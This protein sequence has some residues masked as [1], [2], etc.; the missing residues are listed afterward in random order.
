MGNHRGLFDG[1]DEKDELVSRSLRV[2][3]GTS[4][5]V[6]NGEVIRVD[7]SLKFGVG[8]LC[9][10]PGGTHQ[11]RQVTPEAALT[12]VRPGDFALTSV[13]RLTQSI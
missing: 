11:K 10:C 7:R 9:N 6:T 2:S 13:A 4:T 5:A 8:S 12:V 1:A 3:F